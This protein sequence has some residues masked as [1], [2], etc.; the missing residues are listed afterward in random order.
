MHSN[1]YPKAKAFLDAHPGWT[2]DETL[3]FLD[4]EIDELN[5]KLKR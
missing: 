4:K 5:E 3:D 2:L 1:K